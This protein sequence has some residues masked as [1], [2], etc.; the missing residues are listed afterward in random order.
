MAPIPSYIMVPQIITDDE[1]LTV[2]LVHLPKNRSR[3]LRLPMR[4]ALHSSEKTTFHGS[5]NV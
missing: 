4:F 5:A 3:F 1:L 2:F